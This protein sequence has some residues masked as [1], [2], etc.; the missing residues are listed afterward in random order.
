MG[1]AV[2]AVGR[3]AVR[4]LALLMG[5]AG[6]MLL[7]ALFPAAAL[8]WT[9]AGVGWTALWA[10]AE[11]L[12]A[13]MVRHR[14]PFAEVRRVL[15]RRTALSLGFGLVLTALLWVPLLNL[16]LVPVAV[17]AGTLLYRSLVSSGTLS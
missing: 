13:P 17:C 9:A 1:Q 16:F 4:V 5:Q 8:L 2:S 10:C 11:Y 14:R 7:H 12:D 15:A 3:T 6:L